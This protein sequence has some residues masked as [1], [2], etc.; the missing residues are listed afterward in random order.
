MMLHDCDLVVRVPRD[1]INFLNQIIEGYEYL[2]VVTTLNRDR[3]EV[4]IRCTL[5]TLGDVEDVVA[6]LPFA[7][8][9]IAG[10]GSKRRSEPNK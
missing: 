1:R 9:I 2:G 8:E 10:S 6:T 4:L 7:A 3:N 5:D